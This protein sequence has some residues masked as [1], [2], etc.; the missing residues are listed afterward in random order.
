MTPTED[1]VLALV[2]PIVADLGLDLYDIE[3][4]GGVL[5]ILLD[6]SGGVDMGA[7]TE[8]TR[9][10]SRAL[11]SADPIPGSYTLEVSSPGIERT[12]RTPTHFAGAIGERVKVKAKPDSGADRRFDG[13]LE[14]FEAPRFSVRTDDG[15]VVTL[16]IDQVERVRTQFVDTAAPKPGKGKKAQRTGGTPRASK[17]VDG[18][19]R[20]EREVTDKSESTSRSETRP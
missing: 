9:R 2:T 8:A 19:D 12:L 11:D 13:V 3:L 18:D 6:R 14:S 17:S 15:E 7:I 4:A 10:I 20:A 1:A 16:P 5:R